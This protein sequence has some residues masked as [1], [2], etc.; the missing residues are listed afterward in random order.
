MF[1]CVNTTT[2]IWKA[3]SVAARPCRNVGETS[4]EPG[5]PRLRTAILDEAFRVVIAGATPS[6]KI[7]TRLSVPYNAASSST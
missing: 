2:V 4:V 5:R 3:C 7:K 1:R 6:M